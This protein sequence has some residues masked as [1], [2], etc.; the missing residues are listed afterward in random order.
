MPLTFFLGNDDV[1]TDIT[2]SREFY[3]TTT[4]VNNY[5]PVPGITKNLSAMLSTYNAQVAAVPEPST[6]A[7][8]GLGLVG[9]AGLARRRKRAAG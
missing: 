7:L 4:S 8:M 5:Y 2:G 1:P 6:V 9:L 3:W